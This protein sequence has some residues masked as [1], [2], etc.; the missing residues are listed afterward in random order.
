MTAGAVRPCHSSL[1][2]P[3]SLVTRGQVLWFCRKNW[4][5]SGLFFFLTRQVS[6]G[7]VPSNFMSFTGVPLLNPKRIQRMPHSFPHLRRAAAGSW[8]PLNPTATPVLG[9]S[10]A[11]PVCAAPGAA[12]TPTSYLLLFIPILSKTVTKTIPVFPAVEL[13]PMGR[14]MGQDQT[15]VPRQRARP[16]GLAGGMGRISGHSCHLQ[17]GGFLRE[18]AYA[19]WHRGGIGNHPALATEGAWGTGH[20]L[21]C[22]VHPQF[23]WFLCPPLGE[24]G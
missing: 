19:G 2:S 7:F 14:P 4:D 10:K 13:K 21:I 5:C 9:K 24:V 12:V 18:V 22:F 16:S 15:P 1:S 23:L 6:P 3:S 11:Q 20:E 8:T 17:F